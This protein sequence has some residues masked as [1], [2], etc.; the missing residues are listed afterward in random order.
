MDNENNYRIHERFKLWFNNIREYWA[1]WLLNV[2]LYIFP[3]VVVQPNIQKIILEYFL[4]T[5]IVIIILFIINEYL[6]V[7]QLSSYKNVK[8]ELKKLSMHYESVNLFLEGLPREFL[9]HVSKFLKL[10]N[11]E[12]ISLYVYFEKKFFIIGRYSENPTYNREGRRVYPECGYI[13]E[14]LRNDNGKDYYS[15]TGL[16]TNTSKKYLRTVERDTGMKREDIEKLSMK[17]RSYFTK[18]IKDENMNNVGVLVIESTNE[19]LP[20]EA[21]ELNKKLEELSVSQMATF[22]EVSNKLKGDISSE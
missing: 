6:K 13:A 17:S 9:K 3:L 4:Y 15:K 14:C 22:L 11:S 19:L 18:V 10:K 2:I 1:A 21:E 16:P 12:R 20:M 8:N 5:I 7:K